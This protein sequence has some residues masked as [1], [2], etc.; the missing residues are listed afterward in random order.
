MK[1]MRKT[2]QIAAITAAWLRGE[3]FR[4]T[5]EKSIVFGATR[6]EFPNVRSLMLL[7]SHL[8]LS[9]LGIHSSCN[10]DIKTDLI[11]NM[12]R[13]V[14]SDQYTKIIRAPSQQNLSLGFPT[15]LDS[16]QPVQLQRLARKMK[17]RL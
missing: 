2:T 7:H 17:L 3:N 8:I 1:Y 9:S 4:N 6:N 5:V 15:K 12:G 10:I 11:K 16:N 14:F 13:Y